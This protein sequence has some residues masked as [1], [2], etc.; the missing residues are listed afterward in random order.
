MVELAFWLLPFSTLVLLFTGRKEDK[1]LKV[2]LIVNTLVFIFPMAA[3]TLGGR[4]FSA[5]PW[6]YI[7]IFPLCIFVQVV[8]AIILIS[9]ILIEKLRFEKSI[10]TVSGS[11][12]RRINVRPSL[13]PLSLVAF[14]MSILSVFIGLLTLEG[15]IAI[16]LGLIAYIVSLVGRKKFQ[17]NSDLYLSETAHYLKASEI[18]AIIGVL[19]VPIKTII[20]FK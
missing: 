10:K 13:M 9:K 12:S 4:A 19:L 8:V 7:L 2:I 1:I 11:D 5:L 20:F 14:S 3:V 18:I 17:L 6:L 15:V 16:T